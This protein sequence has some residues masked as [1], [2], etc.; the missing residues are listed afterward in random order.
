MPQIELLKPVYDD[1]AKELA[2]LY[3]PG[4][5]RLE[6]CGSDDPGH[7]VKAVVDNPYACTMSRNYMRDPVLKESVKITRI[8]NHFI[9]SIESVGM[10]SPAVILAESLKVLQTKCS[11]LIRLLDESL[12]T[13]GLNE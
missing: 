10:L 3:E 8:P 7:T 6:P 9:F 2:N 13:E 4:V 5:F 1:S 11:K 12:E